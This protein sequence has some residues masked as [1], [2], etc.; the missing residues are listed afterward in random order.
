MKIKQPL[1]PRD[2]RTP[3]AGPKHNAR[4]VPSFTRLESIANHLNESDDGPVETD[5]EKRIR[6]CNERTGHRN[7]RKHLYLSYACPMCSFDGMEALRNAEAL[8]KKSEK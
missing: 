7:Q 3:A 5:R 8:G 1:T 4:N 2:T 6:V